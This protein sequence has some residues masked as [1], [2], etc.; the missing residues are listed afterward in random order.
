[1]E[2][3]CA[4]LG[5]DVELSEERICHIAGRHPDI[6]P[7]NLARIEDTLADADVVRYSRRSNN[8]RLISRWFP[9]LRN[10]KHVVVVVATDTFPRMRHWV[11]TAYLTSRVPTGEI[12][13]QKD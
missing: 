6:L 2:I 7:D 10:G 11:V 9:D 13:W 8:T 4:Y 12:E 1:M 3:N 5:H